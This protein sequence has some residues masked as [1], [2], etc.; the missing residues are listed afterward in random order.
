MPAFGQTSVNF[1]LKI[2]VSVLNDIGPVS[3]SDAVVT[4]LVYL[5]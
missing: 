2:S 3:S 5:L 1:F 4:G